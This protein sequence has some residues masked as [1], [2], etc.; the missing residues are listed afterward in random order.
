MSQRTAVFCVFVLLI[1]SLPVFAAAVRPKPQGQYNYTINYRN[2][3]RG[4]SESGRDRGQLRA[5]GVR[6]LGQANADDS[7]FNLRFTNRLT[8]AA[9]QNNQANGKVTVDHETYGLNT[10]PVS[11]NL[12][13]QKTR[14]G[15]WKITGNYSGRS[16]RGRAKGATISGRIVAKSI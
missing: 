5:T 11:A 16:T 10:G 13:I 2:T 6:I 7:S 15:T 1:A 12:R 4:T 14:A 8:R 9:R 3:F